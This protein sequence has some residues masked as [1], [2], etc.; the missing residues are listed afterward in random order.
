MTIAPHPESKIMAV[1][2]LEVP[3]VEYGEPDGRT[4]LVLLNGISMHE[5]HWGNLP[6]AL[7]R[8]TYAVGI[9]HEGIRPLV[10]TI[11]YYASKIGPAIH[12]IVGEKYSDSEYSV[13][14]LSWGGLLAQRLHHGVQAR[15]L[16]ATMPATPYACL[17]MP[18][19]K[20]V[21][22]V[23]SPHRK[24]G[25]AA[26]LYGGDV[27][28]NPEIVSELHIERQIDLL[29][30]AKQ[31]FAAMTSGPL[32][33]REMLRHDRPRTLVM[34]GDDDPLMNY[35]VVRAGARWLGAEFETMEEGGHGF[36]LTRPKESADIINDFL[37]RPA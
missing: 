16:A 6:E 7:D 14:G 34:A 13:L 29:H 28:K 17:N 10:T 32:I 2:G 4:P 21:A 26:I 30:H 24:P 25:D 8:H 15:I 23:A 1:G 33:I 5:Y 27:K 12:G 31:T 20:A 36:L 35:S 19:P 9:P 11:G 3:Y 22:V 18:N 37:D